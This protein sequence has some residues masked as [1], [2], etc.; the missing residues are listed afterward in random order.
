M[1]FARVLIGEQISGEYGE[2]ALRVAGVVA[3]SL[4][5]VVMWGTLAGSMLP[6]LLK[7]LRVDPAT[8]STPFIASLVDVTGILIFVFTA[9]II[10]S[11]V[12]AAYQPP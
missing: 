10:M 4:L 5:G 12:I 3:I 2:H 9:Q 1:G 7:R 6:I 11:N 8:S